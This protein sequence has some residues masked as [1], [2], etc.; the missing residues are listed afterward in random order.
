M[1]RYLSFLR[2]RFLET[3]TTHLFYTRYCKIALPYFLSL[4]ARCFCE[5]RHGGISKNLIM[6]ESN[7]T[8]VK[9]L[10]CGQGIMC[11]E[12]K[13]EEAVGIVNAYRLLCE[14]GT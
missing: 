10:S 12:L 8:F 6:C 2:N 14:K 4:Q 3:I 1:Q 11:N 7:G 5:F 9:R 13:T